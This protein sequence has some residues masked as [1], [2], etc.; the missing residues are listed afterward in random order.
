MGLTDIKPATRTKAAVYLCRVYLVRILTPVVAYVSLS[1]F[2]ARIVLIPGRLSVEIAEGIALPAGLLFGPVGAG[3]AALGSV[4]SD[5]I[6]GVAGPLSLFGAFGQLFF[7]LVGYE[8]WKRFGSLPPGLATVRDVG[9]LG[10]VAL[11][12]GMAAT[13]IVG[14]GYAALGEY[15]FFVATVLEFPGL[16][17]AAVGVSV[18]VLLVLSKVRER[19]GVI[20]VVTDPTPE[21]DRTAKSSTTSLLIPVV[22]Y[23]AGTGLSVGYQVYELVP[24]ETFRSF[25][26]GLLLVFNNDAVF[27]DSGTHFQIVLGS[28]LFVVLVVVQLGER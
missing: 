4:L 22:W 21:R 1:L 7:G 16:L 18:P 27:G 11:V 3:G 24:E 2:P 6:A 9:V 12:G 13:A 10:L 28:F 5:V 20:G 17:I 14:W 25:E 15:P 8:L 19:R 26:L 23:L